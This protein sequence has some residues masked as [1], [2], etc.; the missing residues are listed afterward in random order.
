MKRRNTPCQRI[1]MLSAFLLVFFLALPSKAE[2][3]V[4]IYLCTDTHHLSPSLT[5]YGP[6]FTNVVFTN[7]GKL[8]EHSGELLDSFLL[9]AI[10]DEADYIVITGD[11]TFDGERESLL[12]FVSRCQK[13]K[14]AKIP[15]LLIPGNHDI[16]ST[17]SRNYF[18]NKSRPV[19]NVSQ[20]EFAN[21]C[22]PLGYDQALSKD[23]YSFSYLYEASDSLWLLFLDAN[24]DRAPI[25]SLPEGTLDWVELWLQ[26]AKEEGKT[27]LSFSHQNL[28][29]V[30]VL[31]YD[32]FTIH[33]CQKIL[34]LYEKYGVHYSFSGHSHIQHKT[35]QN[36]LTEYVTGP[37]CVT[38]LHYAIITAGEEKDVATYEA[39]TMDFFVEEA[40]ERFR[41][42]MLEGMKAL[43]E[44]LN[45]TE[46]EAAIMAEYAAT[47]NQAYFAG[48][49]ETV[50]SMKDDE[51][52]E[53]WKEKALGS[54]WYT[55]MWS[56]F[57]AV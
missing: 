22:G 54:F 15:V 32:E 41:R 30:N 24:T 48:D 43:A 28:L 1:L 55:Y 7:D 8:A 9:K 12:D 11:L 21:I 29:P 5:D 14:E 13:A 34:D 17:K 23:E 33:D 2:E 26:K 52:W 44:S 19:E 6:M 50:L 10:E 56:I 4:T 51:G 46:E 49:E 40:V 20:E 42:P 53:L 18:E 45:V 39:H 36:G 47:L 35:V 27:V 38:P 37:L 3:A 25:G 57:E 16:S 31:Y